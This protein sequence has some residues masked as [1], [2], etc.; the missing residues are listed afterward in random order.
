M[1]TLYT[2]LLCV[3]ALPA[4]AADDKSVTIE[5]IWGIGG[6]TGH[7]G[8]ALRFGQDNTEA[9][10]AHWFGS[11]SNTAVGF[12]VVARTEDNGHNSFLNAS[13]QV[14]LSYVFKTNSVLSTH[15]QPYFRVGSTVD[16]ASD[17]DVEVV[18]SYT[19]YGSSAAEQFGGLGLRINDRYEPLAKENVTTQSTPTDETPPDDVPPV[20]VPPDCTEDCD[21]VPPV[22]VPPDCTED[23]GSVPPPD[24]PPGPPG[25]VPPGDV[26]PGPPGDVPPGDVPPGPP[27]DVPPG[28]PGDVPPGDVPPGPPGDVPP[29]P[30][31]SD[32]DGNNGHG[33][34]ADGCDESNPGNSPNC[35]P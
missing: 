5:F 19:R 14:G 13:G 25:D 15:L 28:P 26:P 30:P 18:A 32:D 2:L 4:M 20:D 35:S 22:D 3:L 11:R 9:H 8:V 16:L 7:K 23:C 27:G 12:G 33:N 10:I 17:G 29:P 31:P 34:D 1:K 21:D 6:T 24:V